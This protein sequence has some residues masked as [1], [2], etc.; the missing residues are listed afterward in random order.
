MTAVLGTGQRHNRVESVH[1]PSFGFI[2]NLR[3]RKDVTINHA[4]LGVWTKS[5]WVLFRESASTSG[6]GGEREE[7]GG[8]EGER[9]GRLESSYHDPANKAA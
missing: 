9:Q 2:S 6:R 7:G 3:W 1:T 8:G 4:A 5:L